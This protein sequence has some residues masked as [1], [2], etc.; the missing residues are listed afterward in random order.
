MARLREL[1]GSDLSADRAL[2]EKLL[3]A[4]K[5][6][7]PVKVLGLAVR[8]NDE[9]LSDVV[10]ALMATTDP[11]VRSAVA[12][13]AQRFP[14]REFGQLAAGEVV[15][16]RAVAAEST[17]AEPLSPI[18]QKPQV[19]ASLSG[20]LEV[21]GLP[22]LLQSL[23]QSSASGRLQVRDGEGEMLATFDLDEGHLVASRCGRLSGAAAFYQ[24]FENPGPGTFE[25]LRGAALGAGSAARRME[26]TGLLMEAMRR[27]DELQQA[28]LVVPD[29][30]P[31][32][33]GDEKPTAPPD[34][35]DGDFVRQV[36]TRVRAGSTA[37]AC[38]L[39]VE[40]DSYRVRS[41]LAHW[42]ESGALR[43]E[44]P[45]ERQ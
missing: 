3:A 22:G 9:S 36:W 32:R 29:E 38:E 12:E 8:R 43:F 6:L 39:E 24:V 17:L 37:R 5:E 42:V 11:R 30:A 33:A 21:F 25:F 1:G 16:S 23:Q 18:T 45:H 35:R 27:F 15:E 4:M 20:D 28:R 31:L 7:T 44:E 34:E 14:D 40:V 13:L 10:R 2:V 26:M 41:L 19:R